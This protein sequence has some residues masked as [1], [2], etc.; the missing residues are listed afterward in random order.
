MSVELHRR[1]VLVIDD[2]HDLVE[3]VSAVLGDEGY[4]V[5][6][7]EIT[8]DEAIA[9]AIGQL[10]PDCILLDSVESTG[11][12]DAWRTAARIHGRGRP[13]PTVMFTAHLGDVAEAQE[14][15]SDRAQ[16]AAF[17]ALLP[18]PFHL[19]DLLDAVE[20]AVGQSVPFN[21]SAKAE[22]IRTR[23]LVERLREAG[24]VDIAPS[25]R[26]EWANFRNAAGDDLQL[27]WWQTAGQYL[28]ARYNAEGDR[29]EVIGRFFDLEDAVQA[30]T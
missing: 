2:D 17:A 27:Y 9:R 24:A 23:Q 18:K 10:E 21:R 25:Q 13:I 22:R 19:D 6:A 5:T 29:L 30:A 4:E 8:T 28:V 14:G 20:R 1:G 3:V 16:S 11:Y 12:G 26:R 7:L 15:T